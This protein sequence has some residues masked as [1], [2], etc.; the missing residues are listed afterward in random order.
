MLICLAAQH[1]TS[2][3]ENSNQPSHL[4]VHLYVGS[5]FCFAIGAVLANF[6][7][8]KPKASISGM[9]NLNTS[10]LS[11]GSAKSSTS[12]THVLSNHLNCRAVSFSTAFN[13]F[14]KAR[15]CWKHKFL[16]LFFRDEEP[17][18][19]PAVSSPRPAKFLD[20]RKD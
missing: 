17:I 2:S 18:Y 6:W 12:S 10:P 4:D 8:S 14:L 5:A 15:N 7:W 9:Q 3:D 20:T 16:R 11:Q 1:K 13:A 19:S